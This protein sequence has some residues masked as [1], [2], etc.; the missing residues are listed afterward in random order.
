MALNTSGNKRHSLQCNIPCKNKHRID[1]SCG[2]TTQLCG[3]F[4]NLLI[5]VQIMYIECLVK[6]YHTIHIFDFLLASKPE[7]MGDIR[8]L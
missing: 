1:Y 3:E 8:Y 5:I 7:Q 4:S 6:K 2:G